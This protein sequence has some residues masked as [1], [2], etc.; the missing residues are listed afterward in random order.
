MSS[1][2]RQLR[3]VGHQRA[4]RPLNGR[5]A[6]GD[7]GAGT[8]AAWPRSAT[9]TTG[10]TGARRRLG[11]A[12]LAC[13]IADRASEAHGHRKTQNACGACRWRA[14]TGIAATLGLRAAVS[15]PRS[16]S[17]RQARSDR[18]RHMPREGF[19]KG[20]PIPERGKGSEGS[21]GRQGR[22][23]HDGPSS[24]QV[25]AVPLDQGKGGRRPPGACRIGFRRLAGGRPRVEDRIDPASGRL[26]LVAAHEQ[27]LAAA[28]RRLRRARPWAGAA[29]PPGG[30]RRTCAARPGAAGQGHG[31][32][33]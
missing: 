30:G 18:L 25:R 12:R 23:G 26:N 10:T 14:R 4:Q 21:G 3:G 33:R 31:G 28:A 7:K 9:I 6:A 32:S 2:S 15:T 27:G 11:Q 19:G 16:A 24:I 5:T 20:P 29:G 13:P 1:W 17:L 8:G 22:G